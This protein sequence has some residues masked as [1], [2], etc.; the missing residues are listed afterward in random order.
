MLSDLDIVNLCAD[1]Y[2]DPQPSYWS[3]FETGTADDSIC[4]GIRRVDGID[5]VIFRGSL[6]IIDWVRD[7]DWWSKPTTDPRLGEVWPGFVAGMSD[8]WNEIQ[9]HIG[10]KVVVGG[11]S[12]GA[13]RASVLAGYMLVDGCK[14]LARVCFGEPNTGLPK[15]CSFV[16]QLPGRT[17][18]NFGDA[19]HDHVTDVPYNV[20]RV[21][22]YGKPATKINVTA[23]P[24]GPIIDELGFFSWHHIQLYAQGVKNL[25]PI[26]SA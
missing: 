18:R 4:Y 24:S 22:P 17:Y 1:I 12:L 23:V 8:A 7:G 26:G 25:L 10:A 3:Y 14:P 13:A 16:S 20:P 2:N 11:H 21:F 15:F 19:G 9:R 6:S 5:Y